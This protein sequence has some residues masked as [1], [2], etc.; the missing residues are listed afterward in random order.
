MR[1]NWAVQF[2]LLHRLEG[3]EPLQLEAHATAP[4]LGPPLSGT[5]ATRWDVHASAVL[6]ALRYLKSDGC[7]R[8]DAL[9]HILLRDPGLQAPTM[10]LCARLVASRNFLFDPPIVDYMFFVSSSAHTHHARRAESSST[11]LAASA[12]APLHCDLRNV[13]AAVGSPSRLTMTARAAPRCGW[14]IFFTCP[15]P[16]R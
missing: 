5:R 1:V 9:G 14:L 7:H 2:L 11:H 16:H 10:N 12:S 13:T 3:N 6:H 8:A 4:A 15:L